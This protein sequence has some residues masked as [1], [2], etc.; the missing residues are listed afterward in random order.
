MRQKG[1]I[2]KSIFGC[3]RSIKILSVGSK[4]FMGDLIC[5]VINY[6]AQALKWEKLNAYDKIISENLIKEM[7]NKRNSYVIFQRKR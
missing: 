2:S 7:I 6:C 4:Y 3:K 1:Y 5:D